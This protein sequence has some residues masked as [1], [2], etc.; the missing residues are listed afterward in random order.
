MRVDWILPG[1]I[2]GSA[3][4]GL[5]DD[6]EEDLAQLE[7]L[8]IRLIVNL[9]ESPHQPP[10]EERGFAVLHFAIPDMGVSTPRRL[11]PLLLQ[12]LDEAGS[13]RPV[14]VHCKAGLG[15]TGM[16]LACCLVLRG[17]NP[18]IA[19]RRVRRVNP[20]FIQNDRQERFVFDFAEF[21]AGNP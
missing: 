21:A 8:G 18:E 3:R 6:L 2:A 17:E 10:L 19:I 15:R 20:H 4:P 5:L 1:L 14:L 16:V 13:G 11:L 9:T 7:R 12:I